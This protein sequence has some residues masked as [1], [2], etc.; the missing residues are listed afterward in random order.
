MKINIVVCGQFDM[1][2]PPVSK[3]FD[4]Q[5]M[6]A[7]RAVHFPHILRASQQVTAAARHNAVC[8]HVFCTLIFD[9]EVTFVLSHD[10]TCEMGQ[11]DNWSLAKAKS[12]RRFGGQP[13]KVSGRRQIYI[14]L[15][16]TISVLQAYCAITEYAIPSDFV[17][18]STA[19]LQIKISTA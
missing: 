4:R 5:G 14:I 18:K 16:L 3:D 13:G 12:K 9:K 6:A 11:Y 10:F 19:S 2:F 1:D 17:R 8:R 15:I 7:S